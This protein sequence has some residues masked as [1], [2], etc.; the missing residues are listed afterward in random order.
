MN[1][2]LS[3]VGPNLAQSIGNSNCNFESYVKQPNTEFS[4]FDTITVSKIRHLL[5]RLP[6]FKATGID[7]ISSKI[8]K[9]ASPAIS[10]TLT[11]ILN[12]AIVLSNFPIDCKIAR[13]TPIYKSGQRNLT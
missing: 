8:L 11:Y 3:K 6:N 1:E 7:K 2:Y 9:I 5:G 4:F 12:Q 10:A 13:V